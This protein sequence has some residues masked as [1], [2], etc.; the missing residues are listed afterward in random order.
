MYF[1][2]TAA[3]RYL[4]TGLFLNPSSVKRRRAA[5]MAMAAM[6]AGRAA[7]RVTLHETVS[8]P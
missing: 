5:V 8:R 2:R 7:M 1:M 6:M 3:G 4:E